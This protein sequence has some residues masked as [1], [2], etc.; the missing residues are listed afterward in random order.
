VVAAQM[1]LDLIILGLGVRIILEAVQRGRQ[2]LT[3][4]TGA[5]PEAR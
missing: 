5:D 4:E 1:I 3:S 2:R